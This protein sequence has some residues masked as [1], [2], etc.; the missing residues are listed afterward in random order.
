MQ[1]FPGCD[2]LP[3]RLRS[4][5]CLRRGLREI[6]ERD[7]GEEEPFDRVLVKEREQ[8]RSV[9][10][11]FLVN[12]HECS[13]GCPGREDLLEPNIEAERG[14]LERPRRSGKLQRAELP[15]EQV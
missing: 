8:C 14:K 15:P 10:P 4:D 12:E 5:P 13:T 6:L 9:A 3:E 11:R 1:C 2:D 7:E